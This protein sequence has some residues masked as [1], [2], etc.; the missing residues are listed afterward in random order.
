MKTFKDKTIPQQQDD[1]RQFV[2]NEVLCC[3]TSM[4][5]ELQG[6]QADWTCLY[7]MDNQQ[8]T[9]EEC[10]KHY[11]DQGYHQEP[12]DTDEMKIE[13]IRDNREDER[14][15]LEYHIVTKWFYEKLKENN[16][17]VFTN[18]F[19]YFWGRTTSGQMIMMDS[20]I[21]TIYIK[22]QAD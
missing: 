4:I 18:D 13:H 19:N 11:N 16:E 5:E 20:I 17:V 22:V 7:E 2:D 21:E 6:Y 3:V 8:L 12:T 1:L 15:P 10:L 9:D 14:E